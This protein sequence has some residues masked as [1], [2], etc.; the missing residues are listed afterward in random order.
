MS[1]DEVE[2]TL[3]D[4]EGT[5][6]EFQTLTSLAKFLEDEINTCSLSYKDLFLNK[7]LSY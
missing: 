3:V 2:I 7:S 5:E 6:R 1:D 4:K